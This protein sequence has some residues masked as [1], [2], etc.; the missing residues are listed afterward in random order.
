MALYMGSSTR[1]VLRCLLEGLRWL[2]GA[3][4]V[5]VA[6]KSG[7][8]QARSRLGEVPLR[9]LYEQVVQPVA[10][11]ATRGAKPSF[12]GHSSGRSLR[13]GIGRGGW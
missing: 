1:E 9:R 13:D 6:G 4:A 5:K 12:A 10:T 7:I 2:W 3:D 11:C 8:S